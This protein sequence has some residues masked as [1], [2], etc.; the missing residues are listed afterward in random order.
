VP[1][2][3]L[4]PRNENHP[5]GS[6]D[7]AQRPVLLR[8]R[9]EVCAGRDSESDRSSAFSHSGHVQR[10]FTGQPPISAELVGEVGTDLSRSTAAAWMATRAVTHRAS[11]PLAAA[12]P[13]RLLVLWGDQIQRRDGLPLA[14]ATQATWSRRGRAA[15]RRRWGVR[16]GLLAAR[17]R[18]LLWNDGLPWPGFRLTPERP[19][20]DPR[21][22]SFQA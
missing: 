9:G 16:T 5:A 12:P 2:S 4:P 11:S 21:T 6:D 17:C 7:L 20:R 8:R 10:R 15:G 1:A 14:Q 19:R 3:P 13:V 22:E 18:Q